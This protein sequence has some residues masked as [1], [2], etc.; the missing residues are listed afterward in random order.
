MDKGRRNDN[1]IKDLLIFRYKIKE[2]K[3]W[4][5]KLL[6]LQGNAIHWRNGHWP[7]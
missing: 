6:K 1:D 3:N 5:P 4:K 7:L 2:H